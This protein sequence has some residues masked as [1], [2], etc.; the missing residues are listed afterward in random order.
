MAKTVYS[1]EDYC[2]KGCGL[3][4]SGSCPGGGP[5][6]WCGWP[7]GPGPRHLSFLCSLSLDSVRPGEGVFPT[8]RHSSLGSHSDG[9]VVGREGDILI[10]TSF[11]TVSL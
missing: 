11:L 10:P 6:P 9:A 8:D 5:R 4:G 7:E 3:G 2:R 1:C